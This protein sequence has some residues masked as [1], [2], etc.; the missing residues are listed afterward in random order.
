MIVTTILGSCVSVCLWDSE[1]K[2]GGINHYMLPLWNGNGL[3]TPK[4]GNI[5]IA[6]LVQK[7]RSMGS[8][9][10]NMKA[11][12][13]GGAE[14]LSGGNDQFQVG[15]RNIQIAMEML[16]DMGIPVIG[17]SVGGTNGRKIHFDTRTGVVQQSLIPNQNCKA[18][19]TK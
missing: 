10:A 6:K 2:I 12:V 9:P 14:V 7:L 8:D 1:L 11:K 13:I 19:E 5:A 18:I 4:Y 16:K 17:R 15:A 3:Q